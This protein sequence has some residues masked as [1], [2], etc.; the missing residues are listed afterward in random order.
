MEMSCGS[1]PWRCGGVSP[2]AED[3]VGFG[4]DPVNDLG[5]R[6]N[7]MDQA[8]ALAGKDAGDVEIPGRTGSGIF[9]GNRVDVLQQFDLA[10]HPA[11]RMIVDQGAA[12]ERRRPDIVPRQVEDDAPDAAAAGRGANTSFGLLGAVAFLAGIE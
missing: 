6:R 9:G 4:D 1:G 2:S 11:P 7:V 5:R 12:V 8:D 3:L 10:S